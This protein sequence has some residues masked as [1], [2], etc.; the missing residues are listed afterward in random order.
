VSNEEVE[1]VRISGCFA[2]GKGGIGIGTSLFS[3]RVSGRSEDSEG[4]LL[5]GSLGVWVDRGVAL[6]FVS[7]TRFYVRVYI[8]IY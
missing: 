1:R 8:F 5:F 4:W 2:V 3:C 6:C 7:L